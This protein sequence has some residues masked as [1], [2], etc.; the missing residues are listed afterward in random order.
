MTVEC[1]CIYILYNF[2]LVRIKVRPTIT[3]KLCTTVKLVLLIFYTSTHPDKP[4][5]C[6]VL[7]MFSPHDEVLH[8]EYTQ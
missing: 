8:L 1:A 2:A 5:C 4:M 6:A 3:L 7:H